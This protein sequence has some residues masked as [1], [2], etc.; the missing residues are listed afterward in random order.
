MNT[1]N[2]KVTENVTHD[3]T[4]HDCKKFE[5]AMEYFSGLDYETHE[6]TESYWDNEACHHD[7]LNSINT[8]L[9]KLQE[10]PEN[11]TNRAA[12]EAGVQNVCFAL[13]C[14]TGIIADIN[15]GTEVQGEVH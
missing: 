6:T 14:I 4:E 11:D 9:E 3:V 1:M 15:K 12:Y 7:L 10:L 2:T 5:A 8:S 13:D